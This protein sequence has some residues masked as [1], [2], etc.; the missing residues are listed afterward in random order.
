MP[1]RVAVRG[2]DGAAGKNVRAAGELH[3]A[4][5]SY[6]ENFDAAVRLPQDDDRGRGA[7]NRRRARRVHGRPTAHAGPNIGT[8]GPPSVGLNTTRTFSPIRIASRSQ[9][10]MLVIIDTPSSSVT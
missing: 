5:S 4:R 6:Q 10:T 3:R 1:R 9:S 7:G 2:I 8:G